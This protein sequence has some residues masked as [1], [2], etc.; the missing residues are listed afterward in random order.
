MKKYLVLRDTHGFQ[1]RMWH[2][3]AIV[4]FSDDVVPPRHFQALDG[5]PV[6][7]QVVAAIAEEKTALSQLALKAVKPLPTAGKVMR[8]QK[9][10]G[11]KNEDF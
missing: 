11:V 10:V 3:D 2:K 5:G 8:N 1:G 4:E 7:K 6:A 9:Q